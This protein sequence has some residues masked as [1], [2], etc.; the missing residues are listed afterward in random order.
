MAYFTNAISYV[1][2]TPTDRLWTCVEGKGLWSEASI[3]TWT[4][5]EGLDLSHPLFHAPSPPLRGFHSLSLL[6]PDVLFHC[7][8]LHSCRRTF[9]IFSPASP[10]QP[11]LSSPIS[12]HHPSISPSASLSRGAQIKIHF[13]HENGNVRLDVDMRTSDIIRE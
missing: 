2:N 5:K 1:D 12:T 4:G 9:H 8:P 7:A 10:N 6:F 13:S 11:F 3:R